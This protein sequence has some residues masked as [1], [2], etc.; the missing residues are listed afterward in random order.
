MADIYPMGPTH[1]E[2]LNE[3]IVESA[4]EI[5]E[6]DTTMIQ[7]LIDEHNPEPLLKGVR[8]YM[9]ENDIEKKRRTYY[10]AAGQ[11]LVDDTKTNNR[12]SHAWHKLFVDQKTQ[13]LVG[14]PIT[15][16]SDNKTFLELVNELA[17]DDFDDIMNE[18]VKN[19]SNKG[20]EYWH[21]FVDEEGEFDYVIFPAEEM[22][23]VYKDNTRRDIL[24]ALRYYSYKG[25][26]GDETQKA[27]LYTDTHVYY[28]EKIDGVYQ[29][30][31]SYGENNPRPH[32]TK[33][34]QAIGW[35]K[36]PIIPFKNNEEMVSDLK[37]YKDLIDDYDSITSGT[38]DSFSDFQ[39]IVYVLK[40]Y[41]GENPKEFTANL[42][43]HSVIK[44]SGDGGVDT[45]RAEIPVDS[46]AKELE[47][48]QDELYKAAQAVDNSPE[49]IGGGATGPA[50]ENLYA[51]LDLKANMAERKIRAGL[52][53]F[54]WFF[55]EYLRNTGKGD[56]NPDKELTMTFTRTR[57]QNDNEIIQSLVQAVTGGIM[58]KETA[59]AKNPYV[60]D[61][62]EELARIEEEM[63]QYAEMQGNLLDDEGGDDDL[64]EDDPN[65]GAAESGGAGQV[66]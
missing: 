55:A 10:D 25:I 6:P 52:R 5:A 24:F 22:I 66:S 58:S 1:T 15:F 59:V 49:T 26:M 63:N 42:R 8:Y 40:N 54:F 53:L 33:G 9:C 7:K 19:M 29:M 38:M 16:T 13:Y 65:A 61:P 4:K 18:T 2:E 12:T 32:M 30:D 35:G 48:I 39:Q 27:E 20:I 44:V 41:D 56:F 50:L 11:L 23:V 21:P 36:V 46:A 51:L 62:E 34:G 45:L 31:Y 60:Q 3:I 47:R 17:D 37:F 28:Y 14:E 43:Y 64:E 57:I